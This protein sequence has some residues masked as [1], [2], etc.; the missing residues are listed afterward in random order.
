[1][2]AR[3]KRLEQGRSESSGMAF[4]PILKPLIMSFL[5]LLAAQLSIPNIWY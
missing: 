2:L 3:K 4:P 5:T 1:M